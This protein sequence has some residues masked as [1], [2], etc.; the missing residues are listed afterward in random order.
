MIYLGLK[1][2][3]SQEVRTFS[4]PLQENVR[5][6]PK[7]PTGMDKE[8]R[9]KWL[10]DASTD[11]CVFSLWEGLNTSNRINTKAENPPWKMHG[12]VV[13]YD[14]PSPG[15]LQQIRANVE[16]ILKDTP[17]LLPQWGVITPSGNH[18]LVWEF[19]SPLNVGD[20]GDAFILETLE[21]LKK[22]LKLPLLLAGLDEAAF[23]KPST[24]YDI[25]GIWERF[26]ANPLPCAEV[27]GVFY[28]AVKTVSKSKAPKGSTE[29]PMDLVFKEIE[30][31]FPGKWPKDVPFDDGCLGPAVWHPDAK[32][33]K[34][35]VYRP[36]GVYCF[37]AEDRLFKSYAEILGKDFT[38]KF[39]ENKIGAATEAIYYIPRVGY[40]RK[41]PDGAWR[42][43][44][45]DDLILYLAGAQGLSRAKGQGNSPSEVESALLHIQQS[46]VLD[47]AVP[48]V[49][50][51]RETLSIAG[52]RFL[53]LARVKVL[54]PDTTTPNPQWGQGFPWIAAWLGSMFTPRK[55]LVYLLAWLKLF[56]EGARNGSLNRGHAVFM[57]GGTNRGKT[58]MNAFWIP[59][60]MGGGSEAGDFLVGGE[61]FCKELLEVGH[62]H[63]DDSLA[64]SDRIQHQKFSERVKRLIANPMV[65]YHPKF[66]DR[67]MVPFNGRLMVTLNEDPISLLMIPDLD[68]NI[69]DKLMVFG[70]NSKPFVFQGNAATERTL[71]QESPFFLN[72]LLNWRP[73]KSMVNTNHR[74]GM[75]N[76]IHP[77]VRRNAVANSYDS[78]LSGVLDILW[79]TDNDMVEL[80]QKGEPWVGTAA[81]LTSIVNSHPSVRGLI[82][83][84]TVRSIGMRLSKLAKTSGTGVKL[85]PHRTKA[86]T[87]S[88]KYA[89]YH[90]DL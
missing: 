38:R 39:E 51:N 4:N 59:L 61:S 17:V 74:W 45:K 21:A 81:S 37:S 62:W 50:D 71:R 70:L 1:N 58:L 6:Q 77:V 63:I 52:R 55:Q 75:Q 10:S 40:Y 31:K 29:I 53:N 32:N 7:E 84:M 27:Q 48:V 34:T 26:N 79:E 35:T 64:A 90:N 19:E 73:L 57:V 36:W 12:L 80:K 88:T 2:L 89:I 46:K 83:A 85:V 41:W 47:G 65:A 72:W 66:V 86:K 82:H 60:L 69:E 49:Y 30:A 11:S 67:Q 87:E 9:R 56:Y 14:A 15:N 23:K 8:A 24:Y 3:A 44:P 68:R 54:E 22:L 78:D 28:K 25:G 5:V 76:Y 42:A 18:R 43:Q 33:Q 13:D 16:Q 20:S